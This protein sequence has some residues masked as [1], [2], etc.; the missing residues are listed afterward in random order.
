MTGIAGNKWTMDAFYPMVAIPNGVYLTSYAGGGEEFKKVPYD[1]LVRN[2]AEGKMKVPLS[3]VWRLEQVAE[4][5]EMMERGEA[6][7]KMVILM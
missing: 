7:G 4:A 2:V 3:K 1:D 6:R 5:H